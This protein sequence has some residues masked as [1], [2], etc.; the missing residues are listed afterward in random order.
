MDLGGIGPPGPR[1]VA[2]SRTGTGQGAAAQMGTPVCQQLPGPGKTSLIKHW[3]ELTDW[4]PF[5]EHYQHIPS[6]M[7]DD[8][9]AY[10]QEMLDIGAIRKSHSPWSSTVV[11]VQKKDGSLM[12]CID[13]GKWNNQTIKDA[14]LLHCIDE[15][16]NSLQWSQWFSW[17]NLKSGYW[18]VEMEVWAY[19]RAIGFLHI[20]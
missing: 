8:M 14:Y 3:I 15:T 17:L 11:L 7:Y 20:W 18:Q 19:H 6:H 5:K 1:G 2:Q 12:F 16:L 13:L 9:K 4:M 10:L